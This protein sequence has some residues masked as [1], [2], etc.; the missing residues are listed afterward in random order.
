MNK[1]KRPWHRTQ[2]LR[3]LKKNLS[4]ENARRDHSGI[5]ASIPKPTKSVYL[6]ESVAVPHEE[7]SRSDGHERIDSGS[8]GHEERLDSGSDEQ[9]RIDSSSDGDRINSITEDGE[10]FSILDE[11]RLYLVTYRYYT[12]FSFL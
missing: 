10:T 8:D 11:G 2:Y 9:E 12:W 3:K 6:V 7:R 5:G 4:G 1:Q